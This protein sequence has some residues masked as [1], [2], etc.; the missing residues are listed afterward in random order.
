M[1]RSLLP[2]TVGM[3]LAISMPAFANSDLIDR[4]YAALH[5]DEV[6]TILRNEGIQAG[7]GVTED[8]QVSASPAWTARLGQI[9]DIEKMDTMFR[10]ALEGIVDLE[11]SDAAVAF[12]EGALGARIARLELDARVALSDTDLEAETRARVQVMRDANDPRISLYEEF[13]KVN[14]LVDS[15]VMGALNANLA[16]YKGMASNP[17]FEDGMTEDFMLTT[18]WGQE[19]EIRKDMWDWTMN[20]S[21]LA[22]DRLSEAEVQTYIDM[23]ASPAGQKLNTALFAGFDGVFETHSFELGRATAEFSVGDD[24]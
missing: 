19:G 18:V 21:A 8:G 9:Y 2:A 10:S 14:S 16:F 4:Y 22:Y 11:G 3:A 17:A 13:I 24:T 1:L 15:N 20:F 6:F 12:F 7:E 5:M 23:S